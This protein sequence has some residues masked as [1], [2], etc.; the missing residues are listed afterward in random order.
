M[1]NIY[2]AMTFTRKSIGT[3]RKAAEKAYKVFLSCDGE[4]VEFTSWGKNAAQAVVSLQP[5]VSLY[6]NQVM[7][8]S[9]EPT[10]EGA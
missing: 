5:A 9:V 4:I 3:A 6:F 7:L 8:V 1:S 2:E 10:K